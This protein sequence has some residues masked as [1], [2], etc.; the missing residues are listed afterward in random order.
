M[1]LTLNNNEQTNDRTRIEVGLAYRWTAKTTVRL[2]Y[3]T[4][5]IFNNQGEGFDFNS[6]FSQIDNILRVTVSQRIGF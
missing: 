6:G 2:L 5:S 1:D 3:T 4:Q